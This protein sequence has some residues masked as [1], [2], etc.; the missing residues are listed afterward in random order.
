M[1]ADLGSLR[2]GG[3]AADGVIHTGFNHDFSKFVENCEMDRRAIEALGSVRGRRDQP[4]AWSTA[5]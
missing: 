4:L 2:K 1:V 5:A 3:A